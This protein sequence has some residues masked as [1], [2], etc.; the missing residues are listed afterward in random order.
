MKFRTLWTPRGFPCRVCNIPAR[1]SMG[2]RFLAYFFVFL[3]GFLVQDPRRDNSQ[4][5]VSRNP[6]VFLCCA[7]S[8]SD[9]DCSVLLYLFDRFEKQP[10]RKLRLGTELYNVY[11]FK[12]AILLL[13]L[14]I[15]LHVQFSFPLQENENLSSTVPA[16]PLIRNSNFEQ[17]L[18]PYCPAD[19]SAIS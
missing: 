19:A 8:V 15:T 2:S 1:W 10:R 16:G 12:H 18:K 13:L 6:A 17:G 3:W 9:D 11:R 14:P 7:K 4:G 5:Y